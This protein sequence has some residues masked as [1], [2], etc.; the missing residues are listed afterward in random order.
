M[1]KNKPITLLIAAGLMVILILVAGVLPLFSGGRGIGMNPG[2][3]MGNRGSFDPNNL[4]E[5][6]TPPDGAN[7]PNGGAPSQGFTQGDGTNFRGNFAGGTGNSTMNMKLLQLIR[8][9]GMGV[10]ILMALLGILSIVGI[11]LSKKWGRVWA[12]IASFLALT[13]T[14]P[15]L[16]QRM[17]GLTLIENL[18]RVTIAIAIVVLCFLPKS[19]QA[20]TTTVSA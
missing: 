6:F 19:R 14:L 7:L 5:G 18:T 3:R 13:I 16:F 17:V 10:G 4:P 12:I 2:G 9:F 20:V 1:F 11:L 15:S 8:G